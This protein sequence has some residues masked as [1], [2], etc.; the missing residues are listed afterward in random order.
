MKRFISNNRFT[1]FALAVIVLIFLI[2]VIPL[3]GNKNVISW[4]AFGYYYYLRL[5]FIDHSM[6]LQ[7]LDSIG[8]V[9][10]KYAP[11][12]ALYQFTQVDDGRFIIRYPVGQALLYL[13][14]FLVAHLIA[15]F[16]SFPADGFSEPYQNMMLL[17]GMI[18]NV[19]GF[20]FTG[21][22][23]RRHFSDNVV[24]VTLIFILFGTNTYAIIAGR[25]LMAQG[26]LFFL[27]AVFIWLVDSYFRKKNKKTIL[28]ISTVF[29]LICLT[30]PTS[31]IIILP[32]L[33]WPLTIQRLSLKA[34]LSSLFLSVKSLLLFTVPVILCALIQFSYWSYAGGSWILDSYGNPGEGFDLLT[35]HT[36]P[37]LFSFRSGWLLYTPLMG[38]VFIFLTVK[39]FKGDFLMGIILSYTFLF[40]YIASSWTNW[41][42]GGSFS[43]RPMIEA[44]VLLSFP[45]AGL[46]NYSFFQR[47]KFPIALVM[48]CFFVLSIWQTKQAK[49]GVI[50]AE[51]NTSAYYFAS[52]FDSKPDSTKVHLQAFN[53]FDYYTQPNYSLP[54]G[55][56]RTK[57][58]EIIIPEIASDLENKE[59]IPELFRVNYDDLSENDYCFIQFTAV[60]EGLPPKN[61]ILVTTFDHNGN[62]GYQ[63]RVA[64]E[65]IVDS[66]L[67]KNQ[68]ISTTVYLTPTLRS[69]DDTFS[70]Y[71][72]NK[73]KEPGK[74]VCLRI[75]VYENAENE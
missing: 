45:L 31:S 66:S 3:L 4:D 61:A 47:G 36:I 59:F 53:R 2:N 7:S 22:I 12:S 9:F 17:G 11:S 57:S 20:V 6:I 26:S 52:F 27:I 56:K 74:L 42:Y 19:L 70:A 34:E 71:L 15:L 10:E 38:F 75:E 5:A 35:P 33:L 67:A 54:E 28:L 55:L 58:I 72:W 37:F 24:A 8:P 69:N 49:S 46:V 18:Y 73:A 25:A 30:R 63:S 21:I 60:F 41:W 43:Q 68:Y 50:P 65:N 44:Y 13:P 1:S 32:A 14:Y 16:G 48:V 29:G 40:I 39:S 64:R 23:L 51:T 62:Y